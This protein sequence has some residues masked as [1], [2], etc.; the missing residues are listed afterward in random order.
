MVRVD[1]RSGQ[2]TSRRSHAYIASP[3]KRHRSSAFFKLHIRTSELA[4]SICRLHSPQLSPGFLIF[5]LGFL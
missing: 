2:A 5:C 4:R 3:R 1:V